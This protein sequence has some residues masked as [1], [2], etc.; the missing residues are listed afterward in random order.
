MLPTATKQFDRA[1]VEIILVPF[2]GAQ[3]KDQHETHVGFCRTVSA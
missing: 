3:E 2:E 1:A